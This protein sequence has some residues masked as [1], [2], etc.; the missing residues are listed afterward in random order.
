MTQ[1][2]LASE[3]ISPA[4]PT[5]PPGN[6]GAANTAANGPQ[7]AVQSSV[8]A[9]ADLT[10]RQ[11]VLATM[12]VLAVTVAFLLLYRFY[13]VVFLLFVAIA[14]QI[15]LDPLVRFFAN[16]GVNKIAALFAIY[17]ALFA[18]IGAVIWFGA[19]PL[20]E[21]VRDVGGTLPTYYHQLRDSLLQAPIGF[22]RGLG[23]VLPA[24]PSPSL[25]MAAVNQGGGEATADAVATAVDA[26][27]GANGASPTQAW[28]WLATGSKAFFGLF[29][30]FA[31]A[32]YWTLEGD[33]IVRRLVLKAPAGRR[34]ELRALVAESQ[35]KIGAFFRGQLILCS[36]IGLAA[37]ITY[38]LLGIPNAFLLGLLMALFESV[39][40]VGPFL[41]AIPAI[42]VTMSAAPD[43]LVWVI[44]A[45]VL[46]QTLESNLLVPTRDGPIGWCQRHHHDAGLGR[47]WR[48]LRFTWCTAGRALGSYPADCYRASAV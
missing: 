10:L 37:T 28:Q 8:A 27:E 20:A 31:I 17:I 21:Q 45:L 12:T 9:L 19:A 1:Q 22:V 5:S 30:V 2:P 36:I 40:L 46:I 47:I 41:G 24:E 34:D 4:P 42:I 32:F 3:L 6:G 16:R 33:L 13:S 48:A 44:G 15:A 29:A 25:F 11:I 7:S 26:A 39:P 43:K 23:L 14:I 38:L 35:S 18:L